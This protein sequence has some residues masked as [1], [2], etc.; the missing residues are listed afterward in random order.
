MQPPNL[1][2]AAAVCP[3]LLTGGCHRYV[4]SQDMQFTPDSTGV[5]CVH[6]DDSRCG[7]FGMGWILGVAAGKADLLWTDASDGEDI[8]RFQLRRGIATPLTIP[9]P[10]RV[11]GH[12]EQAAVSPDCRHIAYMRQTADILIVARDGSHWTLPE[13][14]GVRSLAWISPTEVAYLEEHEFYDED[15]DRR[16]IWRQSILGDQARRVIYHGGRT[17]YRARWSPTGQYALLKRHDHA[18]L[19]SVSHGERLRLPMP[20]RGSI[21]EVAWSPDGRKVFLIVSHYADSHDGSPRIVRYILL[22]PETG[23]LVQSDQTPER[24]SV[25]CLWSGVG[26]SAWTGDS[27]YV[28]LQMEEGTWSLFDP[29]TGKARDLNKLLSAHFARAEISKLYCMGGLPVPGWIWIEAAPT[30]WDAP[31]RVFAADYEGRHF[32]KV[33]DSDDW[34]VSPDG[35]LIADNDSEG[36]V[37]IRPLQLPPLHEAL[38]HE[39]NGE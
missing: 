18:I 29:E 28:V 39:S 5:V 36:R 34:V 32:V 14:R 35:R 33:A 31:V 17:F 38:Q 27:R 22:E 21:D 26:L 13:A 1:L 15:D 10:M 3:L 4:R 7:F 11:R 8:V 20:E 12:P 2:L 9:P 6:T 23:R 25:P 30:S 16:T 19:V 37:A 24:Y